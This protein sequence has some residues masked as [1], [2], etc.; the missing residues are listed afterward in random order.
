MSC[1]SP[2]TSRCLVCAQGRPACLAGP[3]NGSVPCSRSRLPWKG[4]WGVAQAARDWVPSQIGRAVSAAAIRPR[5]ALELGMAQTC[6]AAA[7]GAALIVHHHL[8]GRTR[9]LINV[10]ALLTA[11]ILASVQH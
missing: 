7:P 6:R 3:G 9:L 4:A 11:K 2:F 5:V 1:F 8:P 10:P